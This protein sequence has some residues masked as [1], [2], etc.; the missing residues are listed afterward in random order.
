MSI[1]VIVSRSYARAEAFARQRRWHP[2]TWLWSPTEVA[3]WALI[4][5]ALDHDVDMW[6]DVID[7]D[8]IAWLEAA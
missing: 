3:A 4:K 5:R 7:I 6:S 1:V 2:D 8:H